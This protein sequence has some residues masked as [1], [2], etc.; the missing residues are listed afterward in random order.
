MQG[1]FTAIATKFIPEDA[2]AYE[3]FA[4][5]IPILGFPQHDVCA[6]HDLLMLQTNMAVCILA[7]VP[8]GFIFQLIPVRF[9]V[10][11]HVYSMTL[12]IMY[13]FLCYRM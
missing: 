5:L 11:R 3:P 8:L 9:W 12:G 4:W 7:S 1:F 10:L 6:L 2:L 13:Q